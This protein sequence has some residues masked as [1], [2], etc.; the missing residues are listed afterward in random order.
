MAGARTSPS[1][2]SWAGLRGP[3]LPAPVRGQPGG[4]ALHP[5]QRA[6]YSFSRAGA[7]QRQ[8]GARPVAAGT[9]ALVEPNEEHQFENTGDGVMKFLCLVP[10]E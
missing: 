10:N 4:T 5:P 1:A 9:F 7:D 2:G 8:G 6:R 3:N